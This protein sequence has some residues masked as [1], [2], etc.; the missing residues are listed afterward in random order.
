MIDTTTSVVLTG[1]VAGA[2]RW[3]AGQQLDIKFAI[4]FGALAAIMAVFSKIDQN[5]AEVLGLIVLIGVAAKYLPVLVNKFGW[6]GLGGA[7]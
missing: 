3:A 2:G 5:I 4:G 6:T 7:K 1:A